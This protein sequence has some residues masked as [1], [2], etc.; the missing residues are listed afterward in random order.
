MAKLRGNSGEDPDEI[1]ETEAQASEVLNFDPFDLEVDPP[2]SGEPGGAP[3]V[4][5]APPVVDPAAP[6]AAPPPAP[7][8][9]AV[10]PVTPPPAE[11]PP[12][13]APAAPASAPAAPV[14]PPVVPA[15]PAVPPPAA[16]AVPPAPPEPSISDL[17]A[18]IQRQQGQITE[19]TGR[20]SQPAAPPGQ[21]P[22]QAP[23]QPPTADQIPDYMFEMPDQLVEALQAEDP[24]VRKSAYAHLIAGAAQAIHAKMSESLQTTL[25]PMI[26]EQI[27][28]SGQESRRRQDM[29]DDFY[30][31]YAFLNQPQLKPMVASTAGQVAAE[32]RTNEWSPQMRDEVYRR[33]IATLQTV[34]G[35]V[36]APA[37][38]PAPVPTVP[39][40]G[41][42]SGA[43]SPAV[44]GNPG[45]PA[46][47]GAPPLILD[48]GV[49]PGQPSTESVAAEITH[50]LY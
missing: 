12:A 5:E 44:L 32:W 18:L 19:L 34:Q 47:A 42:P 48:G 39:A 40:P 11:V 24:A 35:V 23:G 2:P 28:T 8:P 7:E 38:A 29:H 25:A 50:L 36:G 13:S 37:P 22:G 31:T 14:I 9:Q 45:A 1:M 15:P 43:P 30:G 41:A 49:R 17:M 16:P 21:P 27:Q 3:P 10:A 6:A 20:L 26:R 46:P 4:P 33:V